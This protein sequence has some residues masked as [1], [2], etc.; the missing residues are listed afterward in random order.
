MYE[1]SCE[2]NVATKAEYSLCSATVPYALL[3]LFLAFLAL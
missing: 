2:L 3:L 1:K